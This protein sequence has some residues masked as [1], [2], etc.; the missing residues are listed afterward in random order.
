MHHPSSDRYQASA[1]PAFIVHRTE[2]TPWSVQVTAPIFKVY[3]YLTGRRLRVARLRV[4]FLIPDEYLIKMGLSAGE[5]GHLAYLGWFS[6]PRHKDLNHG[7]YSVS[8]NHRNSM[9][10]AEVIEVGSIF[11]TCQLVPRFGRRANRAWTSG[12]VIDRCERFL[13]NNFIDH[14]TYQ[15]IWWRVQLQIWLVRVGLRVC[16]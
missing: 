14:H 13:I 10:C 4:V 5:I 11:R 2:T 1:L 6:C 3:N 16:L 12:N 8:R 9:Q 7:M 15:C